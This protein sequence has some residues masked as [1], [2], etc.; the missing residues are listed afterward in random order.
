[1]T[2]P[3][4]ELTPQ[5]LVPASDR[6]EVQSLWIVTVV[7]LEDLDSWHHPRMARSLVGQW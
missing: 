1:M 7:I 5:R 2:P 3:P 6:Y 4:E